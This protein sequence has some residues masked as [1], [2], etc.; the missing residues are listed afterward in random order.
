[1]QEKPEKPDFDTGIAAP[2]RVDRLSALMARFRLA[3]G[4]GPGRLAVAG[5]AAASVRFWPFGRGVCAAPDGA[6]VLAVD[7]GGAENPLIAALPDCVTLDAAGDPEASALIALI[8]AEAE[9]ARCGAEGALARLTEVLLIRLLRAEIARG[10]TSTGLVGG[11]AC[12]R[13]ARA[14]VAMH[15]DP[16]RAWT[17]EALAAEAHLSLSRFAELFT[18]KVGET[19]QAYLRRWRLTLAR[20]ELGQGARVGRVAARLGY[21][22]AEALTRAF[23]ARYGVPPA[24]VRPVFTAAAPPTGA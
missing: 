2:L 4:S 21:R 6:L 20:Q 15:A 3:V 16:G 22:S 18:A 17:N 10:E 9:A 7:W 1:M 23:R 12:P 11:L 19:P 24:A 14:L 13:I 8:L 5:G